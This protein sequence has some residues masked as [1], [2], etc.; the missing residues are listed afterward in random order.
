MMKKSIWVIVS[1]L[2]TLTLLVSACAPAAQE[3]PAGTQPPAAT[4]PPALTE[5]PEPTE[6]MTEE[7]T[8]VMTEEP[9]EVMT[10]E[11]EA[12][13]AATE[14]A[15]TGEIDC[16]GAQ[17]GDEVSMLYQ[18][19]GAEEEQLM[20]I[21]QPL[22]DACG[23]VLAPESTRDQALLDT[24]VQA[25]NPPDIA[26]WNVTQVQ[27]YSDLLVPVTDLGVNE[28]N[29]PS[30]W[31]DLATFGDVWLAMPVKADVKSII[32]YNPANFEAFG[33]EIP[34]TWEELEALVEQM[35]ADGNVPWSMGLES[36]A[37]TGWT[38]SDFIQDILLVQQGPEYVLGIINGE[39]PYNDPGVA[40]A[41]ETYGQWATDPQYTVGGADGTLTIA[42]RDAIF[43]IVTDPP[44]AM[45]VKQS[46]FAGG[47]IEAEFPDLEYGVDYDFFQVPD[48][49]GLQGGSDWMMAFSDEPAVQAI[50]AYLSSD[51]GGQNW[52]NE[53]F[54]LTTNTAGLPLYDESTA[55]GKLA[56]ILSEAEAFTPDIG[57]SI[58]GG[59][60][61]AEWTAI[62]NY[63]NG[64]DLQTELDQASAVQQ[65][66]LETTQ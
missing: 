42:F 15:E 2:I 19:S 52:A 61:T 59:F 16:M 23:I 47:E 24:R 25:G 11:P 6:V 37:A 34:T 27:Q 17:Q 8:E 10:E 55:L 3:T 54:G 22:V 4:E 21:L 49:Q 35:V 60:G 64:A 50:F 63:I 29:I 45:M 65:E 14:P 38:G 18:W 48:I 20:A 12:T 5:E 44:D 1:M 46:G 56:Q 13:E 58:P 36:E 31:R 66:A 57:D 39:I 41:Y 28:A 40:Q 43:A 33:Y 26:F 9:T 7:P 51:L 62:I 32:W 53:E 30:F